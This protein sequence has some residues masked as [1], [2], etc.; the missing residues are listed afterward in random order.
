[1]ARMIPGI[2]IVLLV[3]G[4]A[5]DAPARTWLV[6]WD[7][8]GDCPDLSAGVDSAAASGDTLLLGPGTFTGPNNRK[9]DFQGKDIIVTSQA[10]AAV[11][12]IDFRA[13][14]ENPFFFCCQFIGFLF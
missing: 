11:T 2:L 8:S 1:M 10:G 13:F 12:T 7:G 3:L 4:L 5:A 6:L 14:F 9:V